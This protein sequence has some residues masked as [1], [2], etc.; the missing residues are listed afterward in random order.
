MTS[1]TAKSFRQNQPV[2][3]KNIWPS[4]GLFII[5]SSLKRKMF[6]VAS[7][8][9]RKISNHASAVKRKRPKLNTT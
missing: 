3:L 8:L 2:E 5:A 6:D 7:S 1:S 9:K 4:L